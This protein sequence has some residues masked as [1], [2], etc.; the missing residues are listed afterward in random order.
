MNDALLV[1]LA[2]ALALAATAARGNNADEPPPIPVGFDAYRMWDKWPYLRI[3]VR[4]YMRST[5]DRRGGNEGADASHFLYQEADDFNV[6]L[7]VLG[8]GILYFVRTNRWHGSP[9]HY[10]IDGH[11]FI[12]Q[13][14]STANPNH[15]K[16]NSVFIPQHLFPQ[17]L[18][19]TWATT[20][21]ADLNWV[22][23][24]FEKSLRIAYSRTRYGTGYYIY[25][26]YMP[27]ITWITQPIKSWDGKTPPPNDVIELLGKAG[28]DLSPQGSNVSTASGAISIGPH[29]RRVIVDLKDGPQMIRALQFAVPRELADAFSKAWLRITWDGRAHPSVDAPVNLFFGTG[30]LF[31]RE[32]REFLVKAFP[33]NIRFTDRLVHFATYF[34]MPYMR[35]AAV[36]LEETQ[37]V[38]LREI[39]WKIK[40]VPYRDPHNWVGLFH[41]TYSDHPNPELGED[42]VF[43]DTTKAE[44]GGD[45]CGHFVGMTWVFSHRA[46]LP[47]LE[48]DP[49]F[50]FDDSNSPQCYGTGTEEWG[51]GGDYWGGQT[52]TLPLVGHPVGA[53][54]KKKAKNEEDMIES[55]YRFLVADL[56]PFGKNARIQLEHGGRNDSHEHYK[57][58]VYWY[59]IDSPSL[60]LTDTFNVGDVEDERRHDYSSPQASAPYTLTSRYEWGPD[61]LGGKEVY[62]ATSDVGR[63]TRGTSEFTVTLRPD[64]LGVL[65]RR[66]LDYGFAN[67]RAQV[68]VADVGAESEWRY[69]GEWYL[70]GSNTC[71]YSNPREELGATQHIMQTSN[72]RWR[73][74][75]FMLP[76]QLTEG[77]SKIRIRLQYVPVNIDLWPGQP[78]PRH[79]WTEFRYDVYCFVMPKAS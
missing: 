7:D 57:G 9:W 22:P 76:R 29:E 44:G 68:F 16:A 15:P 61:H 25:H 27:K 77:R 33:V 53:P 36:E 75:E 11:D 38:E 51:G 41:A 72:R 13:E 31:N 55:A 56:M 63:W 69:V 42:L 50:F 43:L 37:G 78:F 73:E 18:T 74:D 5:Y 14:T 54:S 32:G 66:K 39:K 24:G 23:M 65:L 70:A 64:N 1:V 48:G 12:V 8:P 62:P 34:P 10:E 60:V 58:V 35:N 6:T 3:G 40:R 79:G 49:R 59:G 67:Q 30:S 47:T 2:L 19:F 52:M 26:I 46:Y 4:A 20:K 17:P 71:V 28:S 21:G 45:W